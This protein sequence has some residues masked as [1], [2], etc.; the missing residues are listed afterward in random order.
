MF[1]NM[2]IG[3][4]ITALAVIL[5]FL[6]TFAAL[7]GY[8]G[9]SNVVNRV[10]KADAINSIITEILVARQ[11]EKNFMLRKDKSYIE[12]AAEQAKIVK[13]QIAETK[14]KFNQKINKD[15]MDQILN[16]IN[17]YLVAFKDYIAL[18]EE[19]KV[20]MKTM[21]SN[22]REVLAQGEAILADQ[23]AQLAKVEFRNKALRVDKLT[24]ADD[25]NRLIKWFLDVRKNEKEV[26]ISGQ[27][28]YKDAIEKQISEILAL[29]RN[30][31][32][33][34]KL[35]KN[36][37]QI[38]KLTEAINAYAVAFHNF[39]DQIKKQT[40]AEAEIAEA[41]KEVQNVS[42]ALCKNQK[43]KMMDQ[44]TFVN[45]MLI[46][47]IVVAFTTG[48][49][50]TFFIIKSITTTLHSVID[51][52]TEGSEQI[53]SASG[54][55]SSSSQSLAEGA[56][57]QAA[58][59]EETSAS[60][61]EISSMTKQN[62]DN[63]RQADSLMK[64]TNQ[65][66]SVANQSMVDLISSMEEISKASDETQK[67]VKTID[68]IAFQTNLLALNA[69]VEAARAGEAG[70]GFAVVSEEVRN[71][72]LRSA[73]AAKSTAVLIEGT[74]QKV[75]EGSE[76]VNSTNAEFTRVEE[77]TSR[78]GEL[79]GEISA[80][81]NEQAQGVEQ[82]NTAVTEM[83]KVTQQNA[84]N[85]EESA[86]A[87]EEL[88]AQTEDMRSM[89]GELMAMVGGGRE[90]G[91]SMIKSRKNS[92]HQSIAAPAKKAANRK[93]TTNKSGEIS[94]NQAIPLDDDDNFA[95]F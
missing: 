85:A 82:V 64:N 21:K 13:K 55:I 88:N 77:S 48:V 93:L 29:G 1:K 50:L 74:V 12:K 78:V 60:L 10:E 5:I 39:T 52:L 14:A 86:S 42:A 26:I 58:S 44:I 89:V 41:A 33:R 95:D 53:A 4:K 51:G 15:K 9:L 73:E 37:M 69:A 81:S 24:K 27:Q 80:A 36:F 87:S 6:G 59:I 83:D 19:K 46:I 34:F 61:E 22:A 63:A 23:K 49:L 16:A 62:A 8:I 71:L 38:D 47:V 84:A 70:A 3:T 11:Y 28:K 54:Q 65:V 31:K 75:K 17:V 35:E 94:P 43:S 57:E 68:E 79:V 72:A 76:L 90:T 30:L 92:A 67:V 25:A 7:T 32:S 91:F 2:K 45:T 18:E 56:S 66:V 20:N 40:K